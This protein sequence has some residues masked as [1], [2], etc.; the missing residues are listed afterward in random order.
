ME[1][2]MRN[3]VKYIL[4]CSSLSIISSTAFADDSKNSNISNLTVDVL[5]SMKEKQKTWKYKGEQ[6]FIDAYD[7]NAILIFNLKVLQI[8]KLL[9]TLKGLIHY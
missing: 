7:Q 2:K 4:A 3:K 5:A 1:I 8:F 6:A 9:L